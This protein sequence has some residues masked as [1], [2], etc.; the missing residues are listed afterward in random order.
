[1]RYGRPPA[2]RPRSR[3][4]TGTAGGRDGHLLGGGLGAGRTDGGEAG[5]AA[6]V[7]VPLL[8][9]AVRDVQL[10]QGAPVPGDPGE[11]RGRVAQPDRAAGADVD[12]ALGGGQRGGVHGPRHVAYVHEV[13]LHAESAELQLAVARLHRAAHGLG[14]AAERGSGGGTGSD[15][16]EDPQD[17]GVESG[18]Q[19]QLGGGQ[20]AHAVRPTGSRHGVLRRGRSGLAGP[21]LGGAAELH[22]PGPAAAAAQRLADRR[23]G[24]GVVPGEF[25]GPAQ[26]APA[27]LMTTPGWTASRKRVSAPGLPVARSKRTSASSPRP[28][29]V[30]WTAGSASSRSAT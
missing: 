21:V 6:G 19:D 9:S 11:D 27:Q 17:D 18:A 23:D 14:E 29:A 26:V 8:G 12:H 13:A 7:P 24:D 2:A 5:R 10:V 22:Q 16:R 28:S 1:M 20:F 15:G 25:P 30:S 4:G 3:P